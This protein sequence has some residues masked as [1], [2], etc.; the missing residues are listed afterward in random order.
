MRTPKQSEPSKHKP[1]SAAKFKFPEPVPVPEAPT[2]ELPDSHLSE[3]QKTK[4][5]CKALD[6]CLVQYSGKGKE[7]ALKTCVVQHLGEDKGKKVWDI[8]TKAKIPSG[9]KVSLAALRSSQPQ[10][11]FKVLSVLGEALG[12]KGAFLQTD[13]C[14]VATSFFNSTSAGTHEPEAEAA[15][16]KKTNSATGVPVPEPTEVELPQP[17]KSHPMH[18]AD[19][20]NAAETPATCQKL[21]TCLAK[22]SEDKYEQGFEKCVSDFC[23]ESYKA[24]DFKGKDDPRTAL[25]DEKGKDAWDLIA[26]AGADMKKSAVLLGMPKQAVL[27]STVV[28]DSDIYSGIMKSVFPK[29]VTLVEMQRTCN[30]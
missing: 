24:N 6:D 26:K 14:A 2:A 8:Y 30:L 22:V 18:P 23:K 11:Y 21:D 13:F 19:G 25:C 1:D 20:K 27:M 15:E 10:S 17:G 3:M 29:G 4:V 5:E 16:T 12:H 28:H 7:A 9:A